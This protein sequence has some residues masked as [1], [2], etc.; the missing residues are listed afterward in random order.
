MSTIFVIHY[1]Y[2]AVPDSTK[3][4]LSPL[5]YLPRNDVPIVVH[6]YWTYFDTT[7]YT[8]LPSAMAALAVLCTPGVRDM[9]AKRG[10]NIGST[11]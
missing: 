1:I 7:R 3:G 11:G 2:V 6:Y 8:M 4:G 9:N 5:Q 10:E